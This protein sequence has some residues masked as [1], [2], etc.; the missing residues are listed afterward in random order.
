MLVCGPNRLRLVPEPLRWKSSVGGCRS[1]KKHACM[2]MSWLMYPCWKLKGYFGE[3]DAEK[4][5]AW[6]N[7][8]QK[9]GNAIL[10]HLKSI[11]GSYVW[12]KNPFLFRQPLK[13]LHTCAGLQALTCLGMPI[14]QFPALEIGG[15]TLTF[16]VLGIPYLVGKD[17]CHCYILLFHGPKW[18]RVWVNSEEFGTN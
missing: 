17:N 15:L 10:V 6:K 1:V 3:K 2:R 18:L 16:R 4:W 8:F 11:R 12:L 7:L 5:W 9:K 13:P 14:L